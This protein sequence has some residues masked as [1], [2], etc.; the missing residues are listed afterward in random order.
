METTYSNYSNISTYN[1]HGYSDYYHLLDAYDSAYEVAGKQA[2]V[3]LSENL[4]DQTAQTGLALAGWN[5][6][7][8]DMEAQ[9]VDWWKWG[10]LP[11]FIF[12][13]ELITRL[14]G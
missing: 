10:G 1:Q 7:T 12:T 9:T 8:H 4:Q 5:P 11:H 6:N 13:I 2:G 14:R 3:I